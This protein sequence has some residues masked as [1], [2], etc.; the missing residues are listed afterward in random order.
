MPSGQETNQAFIQHVLPCWVL[1]CFQ[2]LAEFDASSVPFSS[3]SATDKLLCN[4]EA[5]PNWPL[6]ADVFD[7]LQKWLVVRRPISSSSSL[8]GMHYQCIAPLAANSL[9]SGLFRAIWADTTP[10]DQRAQWEEDWLSAAVVN[11]HLVCDPIIQQPGFD[12]PYHSWTLLNRFCTGQGPCRANMHKWCLASSPLCD[13]GEQ[14]TMEHIVDSCLLTKLDGGLLSLHEADEDAISWLKMTVM[15]VL[16]KWMSSRCGMWNGTLNPTSLSVT[17][18]CLCNSRWKYYACCPVSSVDC[19]QWIVARHQVPP[20]H[21]FTACR[22]RR[23]PV[24]QS[25][26]PTSQSLLTVS[27]QMSSRDKLLLTSS[28]ELVTTRRESTTSKKVNK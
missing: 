20:R 24:L 14:Q 7:H 10:V 23:S 9:H 16:T 12:L 25:R 22:W 1:L 17:C 13:C 11:S 15:K 21:S 5:H 4:I 2:L 6:Y 18:V 8:F 19:C 26:L 3:R 27:V 28:V